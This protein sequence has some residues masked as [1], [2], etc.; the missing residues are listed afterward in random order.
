MNTIKQYSVFLE[1]KQG[2]LAELTHEIAAAGIDLRTMTLADTRD[3]GILR[4]IVNYPAAVE[5][6]LAEQSWTYQCTEVIGVKLPDTPGGVAS[7]LAAL[8]EANVNVEY[9]YAFVNRTPGRADTIIRVD[10]NAAALAALAA[11]GIDTLTPE[12]AYGV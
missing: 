3:Y 1:N 8:H 2:K 4:I 11:H 7:V 10:D 12:E 5:T 6:L 9:M